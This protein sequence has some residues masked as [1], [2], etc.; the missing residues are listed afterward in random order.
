MN[1]YKVQMYIRGSEDD[2]ASLRKHLAQTVYDEFELGSVFGVEIELD[3]PPAGTID[4][5][6][7]LCMVGLE[8]SFPSDMIAID[9]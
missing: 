3:S 7:P 8:Q 5:A 4:R 6:M 9:T 2:A 1:T